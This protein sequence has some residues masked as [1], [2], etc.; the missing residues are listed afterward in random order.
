[1]LHVAGVGDDRFGVE[2]TAVRGADVRALCGTVV[3]WADDLPEHSAGHAQRMGLV[4][5]SNVSNDE[6]RFA[7]AAVVGEACDE[8]LG[9]VGW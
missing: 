3:P 9:P 4:V 5:E 7:L 1:M 8:L 6:T 2:A